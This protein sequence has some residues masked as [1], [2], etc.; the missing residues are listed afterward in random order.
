M[1]VKKKI[2]IIMFYFDNIF[3]SPIVAN[4][5]GGRAVF[6]CVCVLLSLARFVKCEIAE[7]NASGKCAKLR[8]VCLGFTS[9]TAGSLIEAEIRHR[10]N[11]RRAKPRDAST[12]P[13]GPRVP[14]N[15]SLNPFNSVVRES[16]NFGLN[17]AENYPEIP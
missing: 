6:L 14:H 12:K 4:I 7:F 11:Y 1:K 8:Y 16:R 15:M 2:N 10:L 3:K 5:K 17:V 9:Q 13:D